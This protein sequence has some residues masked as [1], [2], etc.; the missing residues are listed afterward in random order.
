MEHMKIMPFKHILK[1]FCISA[2][3]L[4]FLAPHDA[5]AQVVKEATKKRISIG[6][7]L[8]S[9]IWMNTPDGM[10]TRTINQG[11]NVFATYNVP[12]GK[13][14]FGFSIGLGLSVHNL[15]WNYM[16]NGNN[17]S[18]QF[19]KIPD[20][21]SYK[22]SKLTLPYLELPLEFRFR[23]KSKIAVGVGFKVGYM[24]YAHTKWVG[25]DYLYNSST[26]LRTSVKDIKNI[27]RF[28]YGPTLRVGFKWIHVNGYYSL[29]NIFMKDKG[30]EIYPITVGLMLM[31]F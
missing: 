2:V 15:Y 21:I 16:F 28:T 27:E 24:M 3:M 5:A 20:N 30:P 18:L 6:F 19:I 13:S 25:D 14:N 1:V 17:D 23:S 31:P 8:F 12:F 9:D 26:T 11:V 7:G 29:A 10:K 4:L 22:R